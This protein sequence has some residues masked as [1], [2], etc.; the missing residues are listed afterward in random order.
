MADCSTCNLP[1]PPSPRP[2]LP[3]LSAHLLRQGAVRWR[4][5]E[6]SR[7]VVA[8]GGG[9]AQQAW[10]AHCGL[11]QVQDEHLRVWAAA[12]CPHGDATCHYQQVTC[13][14]DTVPMP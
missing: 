13:G 4:L 12:R 5:D 1:L 6:G 8:A 11:Q 10:P 7:V 2:L 9:S 3:S 14:C